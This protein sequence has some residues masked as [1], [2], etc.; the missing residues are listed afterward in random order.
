MRVACVLVTHLRAR[1]ELRRQPHLD[2]RPAV[3]VDRTSGRPVV[4]DFLPATAGVAAGMTLEQALSRHAEAA[5]IEADEPAYRKAFHR[6]LTSLQAVGDRVERADLGTAYVQM[7]GLE[8]LYRG[9]AGVVCALLDAVPTH[10]A[11]RVGVADAK[12]PALVAAR[13]AEALGARRVPTDV[14]A[15]LAPHSVDLLSVSPE[16]RAGLRRFGVQTMGD[17][18]AMPEGALVDQ[19]GSAGRRAWTLSRGIDDSPLAP[20]KYA[21]AVAE[22]AALPFTSASTEV[23]FVAVDSL[24]RR[25]YARPEMRGRYAGGAALECLLHRAATW[26]RTFRFKQA[27]GSWQS[28]SRILRS[29][30]ETAPPPAPVEEVTLALSDLT[31]ES[32]LQ[33]GLTEEMRDS[34]E[35]RLVEVDRR[36][37]GRMRGGHALYRAVEVAPWHPA[38]EMRTLRVPIDPS[39]RQE[40][41]S[42]S[43]PVAVAVR[44]GPDRRPAAVRLGGHWRRVAGVE[45]TWSF[46]LWWM[47]RPLARTYHRVRLENGSQLTLFRDRDEPRWYR[48]SA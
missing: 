19:F 37:R 48:Q 28:A 22:H 34:R 42:L 47:P 32:G 16:T 31:G 41:G 8:R 24:L 35:R 17:V 25:A 18:A 36:L 12:F 39:G 26:E 21:E 13:T 9:E 14:R 4:V 27:A 40:I 10:L 6:M 30:L 11:P 20:M 23:L 5:V 46:D 44:E 1:I 33:L 3:I 29:R 43:A 45:D 38:P 2:G 7:D 15:F